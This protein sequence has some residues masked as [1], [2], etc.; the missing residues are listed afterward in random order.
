MAVF[1]IT[2]FRVP[3]ERADDLEA[4]IAE[5]A[6]YVGESLGDSSWSAW[7]VEGRPGEYT[8]LLHA[9]DEAAAARHQEAEGTQR[10]IE[11]L[12]PLLEGELVYETCLPV[13]DSGMNL[14]APEISLRGRQDLT[15]LSRLRAATQL[16]RLDLTGCN[17]LVNLDALA[18]CADLEWIDLTG[19][20]ALTDL[21]GLAGARSVCV[22]A[23]RWLELPPGDWLHALEVR[24]VEHI[25][26]L[27]AR[28]SLRRLKVRADF[29]REGVIAWVH[30]LCGVSA[31]SGLESLEV[32]PLMGAADALRA[33]GWSGA[34]DERAGL[35]LQDRASI[36]A[37]LE[38]V[39]TL[40][41]ADTRAVSS[42][43][44]MLPDLAL[45]PSL[46]HLTSTARKHTGLERLPQVRRMDLLLDVEHLVG[47]P[48]FPEGTAVESLR[49]TARAGRGGRQK[50]TNLDSL[51][52]LKSLRRLEIEGLRSLSGRALAVLAEL[53]ALTEL[54][55][56]GCL[57]ITD[58]HFARNL[59]GVQILR[60]L[61][62]KEPRQLVLRGLEALSGVKVLDLSGSVI[63]WS[64]ADIEA[65][66]GLEALER[67]T[68][69]GATAL[70]G[71]GEE[72]VFEGR[73]AIAALLERAVN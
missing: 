15:D 65:L 25:P 46:E 19:C 39:G 12:G 73:E 67:L 47:S 17:N 14:D 7:R 63:A 1:R 2:R 54:T 57:R 33:L 38:V 37:L 24:G 26:D 6:A 27:G 18:A 35:V 68:L 32:G 40:R 48:S 43:A 30:G 56:R 59:P 58:L 51:R 62:V 31:L 8:A 11:R 72:E 52:A 61:D 50:L 21:S 20:A 49:I 13:A 45:M 71:Q 5:F 3:P 29:Y 66:R 60:V 42:I 36:A 28:P 41:A 9:D 34:I 4:A 22:V 10:F 44:P 69:S 55:L 16:R 70:P 23:D 53:P 64:M